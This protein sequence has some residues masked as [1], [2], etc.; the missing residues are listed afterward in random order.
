MAFFYIELLSQKKKKN[1][2]FRLF[3]VFIISISDI[4]RSL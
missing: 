3:H 2:L 4:Q 1:P